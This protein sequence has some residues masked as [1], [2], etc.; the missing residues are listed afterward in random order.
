[1]VKKKQ[2]WASLLYFVVQDV[3]TACEVYE[4]ILD[5]VVYKKMSRHAALTSVNRDLCSFIRIEPLMQ[6]KVTNPQQF[7]IVS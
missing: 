5:K 4:Q 1:M 2:I 6:L 7:Q 3:D